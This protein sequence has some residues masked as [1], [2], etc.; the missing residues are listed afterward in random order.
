MLVD[1]YRGIL[2]VLK[3]AF[4]D[5]WIGAWT[6]LIKKQNSKIKATYNKRINS[7][8]KRL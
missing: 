5:I 8:R 6:L 4:Y 3:I 7:R 1:I 2:I